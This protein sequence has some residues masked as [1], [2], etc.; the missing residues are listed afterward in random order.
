MELIRM[1]LFIVE[2]W[3]PFPSSEYGGVI[4]I[5][6][7]D[8]HQ[9]HKLLVER[10]G[11]GWKKEFNA[12]IMQALDRAIVLELEEEACKPEIVYEFTT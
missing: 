1:R 3:V 12:M 8:K 10:H 5:K 4:V 11:T 9:A 6:A 2:Y 7:I